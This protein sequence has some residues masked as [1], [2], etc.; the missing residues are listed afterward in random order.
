M[1]GNRSRE[2]FRWEYLNRNQTKI[3]FIHFFL[4]MPLLAC[5]SK[6]LNFLSFLYLQ[7]FLHSLPN[8]RPKNF[9]RLFVVRRYLQWRHLSYFYHWRLNRRIIDSLPVLMILYFDLECS[10]IWKE[11]FYRFEDFCQLDKISGCYYVQ[12]FNF[13]LVP[14]LALCPK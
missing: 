7:L 10:M 6:V 1:N 2:S 9:S 14:L 13:L 12:Y 3:F 11:S 4:K 8:N 5:W